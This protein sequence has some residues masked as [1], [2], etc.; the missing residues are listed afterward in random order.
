MSYRPSTEALKELD[1]YPRD[2]LGEPRRIHH[3][4]A[5]RWID[6]VRR[7]AK[8]EAWDEGF[9]QGGPMHDVNLDAPDAH[10]RNPYR[11]EEQ[12]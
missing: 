9:K 7:R 12:G 1:R 4:E 10:T 3:A 6:E 5:G 8:A 2:P 11:E